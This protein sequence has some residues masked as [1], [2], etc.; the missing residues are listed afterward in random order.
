MDK[1]ISALGINL[2][3]LIAFIV[4]FA[5]LYFLLQ[6]FLFGPVMK[7]LD[8]RRRRIADSLRAA[9]DVQRQ[10]AENQRAVQES[11]DQARREGQQLIAQAQQAGN[12]IQD[13]ARAAA[14]QE[15]EAML[16]R[17]RTEIQ[18]ERDSAIGELRQEF[19]ELTIEA[20]EK[21][22]GQSLDRQAHERLINQV[23]A[24]SSFTSSGT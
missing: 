21:V 20:A 10:S 8:E 5:I 23:L 15:Q 16:T 22:I 7:N 12:R 4:N 2:P 13:E 3:T 24:D 1:A 11:L 18:L 6:A 17:A 14:R 9:E 19:A